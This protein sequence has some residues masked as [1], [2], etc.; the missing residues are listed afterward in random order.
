MR[1]L[2]LVVIILSANA[3]SAAEVAVLP[4]H[5]TNI[6]SGEAEAIGAI[7]RDAYAEIAGRD[8]SESK[9]PS[10]AAEYIETSVIRLQTKL[11]I[12]ATL[13]AAGGTPVWT[14]DITAASLDD[15]P[16]AADRLARALHERRDVAETQTLKNITKT[17]TSAPNRVATEKVMGVKTAYIIP[18]GDTTYSQML[19]IQFD[20]RF[21]GETYFLEFGAG[22][23][24]PRNDD[25]DVSYGALFAEFGGSKYL[26]NESIS[27]YIGIGVSPRIVFANDILGVAPYAQVGLMTMRESSTR[28]YIDLRIAQNVMPI[29]EVT[30][31]YD[32]YEEHREEH[33]PTEI[34]IALG[35]GW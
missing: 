28:A 27:P 1:M 6:T 29:T 32:D 12:R 17:E 7:L 8:V 23:M 22:F 14:A 24:V 21:E 25:E 15:V 4:V 18:T 13:F 34:T 3:A 11:V 5:G 30:Y 20:G 33:Y 31:D 26:T 10:G 35:M 19:S 9:D 2:C 16:P